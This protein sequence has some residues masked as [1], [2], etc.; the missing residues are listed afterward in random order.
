MK[1][2]SYTRRDVVKTNIHLLNMHN[3]FTK[4]YRTRFFDF[5]NANNFEEPREILSDR[6][7]KL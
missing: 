3:D 5:I 7:R 6:F 4:L 2:N 1:I